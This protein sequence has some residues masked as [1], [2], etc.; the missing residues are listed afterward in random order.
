MYLVYRKEIDSSQLLAKQICDKINDKIIV[1][2]AETQTSGL[3]RNSRKWSSSPGGL[4]FTLV[5]KNVAMPSP[6]SVYIPLA[7]CDFLYEKYKI[8]TFIK[9]PNDIY[10]DGK[11]ICGI[12]IDNKTS[13]KNVHSFIGIGINYN[14]LSASENSIGLSDILKKTIELSTIKESVELTVKI[15]DCAQY[16]NDKKRL[17]AD[18]SRKSL[19]INR[20]VEIVIDDNNA[21]CSLVKEIGNDGELILE[22]GKKFLNAQRLIL[23]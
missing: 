4:Y 17:I 13:S 10:Y 12:L 6:L 15:L 5:L 16:L 18:Y 20:C 11:K 9:W 3:G 2:A 21:V 19:V 14:N 7:I 8:E 22:N 23:K 1:V